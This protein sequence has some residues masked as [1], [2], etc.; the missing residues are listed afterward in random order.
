MN[1]RNSLIRWVLDLKQGLPNRLDSATAPPDLWFGL[2]LTSENILSNGS[3]NRLGLPNRLDCATA[4]PDLLG[5]ASVIVQ[6]PVEGK[7]FCQNNL[8]TGLGEAS[9]RSQTT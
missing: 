9:C 7:Q 8:P 2:G 6:S 1:F 4:P 3:T 5:S